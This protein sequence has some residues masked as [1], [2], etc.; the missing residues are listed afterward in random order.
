ML[1]KLPLLLLLFAL[2][3][4][5]PKTSSQQDVIAQAVAATLAAQPL[6]TPQ[7]TFTPYPTYTP[8]VIDLRRTFCEYQF[9]IGH[10]AGLAFFDVNE[11]ATPSS[12]EQGMLA[13]YRPDLFILTIWQRANGSDDP[14]FM[15][16]LVMDDE[17]DNR[18]GNL[19]VNL[20]GD[21]TVFYVPVST[22]ASEVL[23]FGGAAAWICGERA[24]GWKVYTPQADMA[25]GLLTEALAEFRCD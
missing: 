1:K 22:N 4:C 9:C 2:A 5:K 8:Q 15:L 25:R 23:P 10:P 19:D 16:D 14:Q 11:A 17:L 7:P 18:G 12:Y 21:L 24:F 3:A 20:I 6:N 13:S